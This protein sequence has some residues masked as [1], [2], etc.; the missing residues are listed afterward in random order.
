MGGLPCIRGLRI[1]VATVV[2]MIADGM[3]PDEVVAELPPLELE[4]VAA[5]L[6]FAADTVS[7]REILL[8]PSA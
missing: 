6:R 4:D 8:Q 2:N 7:D 5:A 3:T 1:P